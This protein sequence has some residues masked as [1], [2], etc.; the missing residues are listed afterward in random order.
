MLSLSSR[1]PQLAPRFY[2]KITKSKIHLPIS[3]VS[4]KKLVLN[5]TE[6]PP[7]EKPWGIKQLRFII[8]AYT[9]MSG[10]MHCG[11]AFKQTRMLMQLRDNA[12]RN[13]PCISIYL[14]EQ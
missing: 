1:N 6:Q 4:Q 12:S 11:H 13:A 10:D 5:I 9:K 3:K 2:E 7:K 8:F 14:G